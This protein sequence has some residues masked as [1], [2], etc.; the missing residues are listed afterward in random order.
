MSTDPCPLRYARALDDAAERALDDARE[1]LGAAQRGRYSEL[2][3]RAI[4]LLSAAR[5]AAENPAV[6]AQLLREHGLELPERE[7]STRPVRR[8]PP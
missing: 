2:V 1:A 5:W 6:G 3:H 8:P 7:E 4:S